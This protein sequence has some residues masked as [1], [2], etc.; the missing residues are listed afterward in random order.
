[1][2]YL[3]IALLAWHAPSPLAD[4]VYKQDI[5][6]KV[7]F[8]GDEVHVDVSLLIPA[9]PAEVWAV[10]T[11]YEHATEFIADLQSSHIVSRSGDTLQVMQKGTVS[12]GPFT[13]PVETLREVQFTPLIEMRSRLISGNMKKLTTTTRVAAEGTG[14]R[15]F[16]HAESVP[17][18]WVPPLIGKL[19]FRREAR[20]MFQQLRNEIVR[21]KQAAASR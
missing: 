8:V 17:D 4:P 15:I 12:F 19:F 18:F 13:F 11:D 2:R 9:T 1:M 20:D 7:D 14:T 3:L 5:D 10:I 21:R 16:N 6:V